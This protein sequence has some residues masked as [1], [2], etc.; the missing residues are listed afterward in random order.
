[1]EHLL[2]GV[3]SLGDRWRELV[4]QFLALLP[5]VIEPLVEVLKSPCCVGRHADLRRVAP[6]AD[7]K[8]TRQLQMNLIEK[9]RKQS[10]GK[11][12]KRPLRL[13]G[14]PVVRAP[15]EPWMRPMGPEGGRRR[16]DEQKG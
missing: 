3:P 4:Q 7:L 6:A 13:Y 8:A 12:A 5:G 9:P 14:L 1:M 10:Q 11:V 15:V 2:L 16:C